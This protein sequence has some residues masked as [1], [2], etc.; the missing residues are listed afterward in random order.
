MDFISKYFR[1]IYK[2]N[3]LHLSV[4]LPSLTSKMTLEV[5]IL[6]SMELLLGADFIYFSE[7]YML[8]P[9]NQL[10]FALWCWLTGRV[11]RK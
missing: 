10:R 1:F 8:P 7:K 6:A 3:L 11:M 4:Y 2:A 5:Y 9:S